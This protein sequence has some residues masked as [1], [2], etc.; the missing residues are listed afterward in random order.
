[1]PHLRLYTYGPSPNCLKVRV[2]LAHLDLAYEQ[3]ETNIFGGDTLTGAYGAVNPARQTPVLEVDG[4]HLPQSNAIL[5]YLADGTHYLPERPFERASVVRWLLFEQ[6]RV[7]EIAALRFRPQAGVLAPEDP[8]VEGLRS[9]AERALELLERHLESRIFLVGDVYSIADIANYGYVHVAPEAGM[10]LDDRPAVR[11]WL[12]RVE[13]QPGF[14]NDLVPLPAD[15]RVGRGL[16]IY[17]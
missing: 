4:E 12:E 2:L 17:G 7:S 1:V 14:V 15:A 5:W 11:A 8:A 13:A 3:V 16:S 9:G 6:E 10:E